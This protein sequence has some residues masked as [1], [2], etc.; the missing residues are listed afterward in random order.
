MDDI[1]AFLNARNKELVKLTEK[2][3]NGIEVEEKGLKLLMTEGGKE[4]KIE[5]ITSCEYMEERLQE[6]GK[7]EGLVLATSVETL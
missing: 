6:C 4:G 7:K 1:T 2:V 3:K 5:A